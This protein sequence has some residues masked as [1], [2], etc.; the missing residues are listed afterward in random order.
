[1]ISALY[2]YTSVSMIVEESVVWENSGFP[3]DYHFLKLART[4]RQR[5]MSDSPIIGSAS[6]VCLDGTPLY[7][8]PHVVTLKRSDFSS[9][10]SLRL[11]TSFLTC[12]GYSTKL[13]AQR[14]I[15]SL[16]LE[17]M[18]K[19]WGKPKSLGDFY[20]DGEFATHILTLDYDYSF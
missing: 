15:R 3:K 2:D 1:M 7:I 9:K 8:L 19:I 10:M 20:Q 11:E 13:W 16:I 17:T 14:I 12:F 18:E 6:S 5:E 4:F